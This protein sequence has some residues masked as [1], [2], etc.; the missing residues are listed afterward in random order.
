MESFICTPKITQK[1]SYQAHNTFTIQPK[2]AKDTRNVYIRATG[3]KQ[4]ICNNGC[5]S[6]GIISERRLNAAGNAHT[7]YVEISRKYEKLNAS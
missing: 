5:A 6:I 3:Y 4:K 1:R 7:T 2:G